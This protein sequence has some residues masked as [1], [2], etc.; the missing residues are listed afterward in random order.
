MM[1]EIDKKILT[2][3]STKKSQYTTLTSKYKD[4]YKTSTG[5]DI[6]ETEK[7]VADYITRLREA[8]NTKNMPALANILQK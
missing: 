7:N 2:N 5:F 4:I 6:T 8:Y 3:F 1:A